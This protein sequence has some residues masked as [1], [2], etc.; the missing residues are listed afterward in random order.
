MLAFNTFL[1]W[2]GGQTKFACGPDSALQLPICKF[3]F[4]TWVLCSEFQ[5]SKARAGKR[6]ELPGSWKQAGRFIASE[7]SLVQF[8]AA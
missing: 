8:L 1:K 7:R 4:E 6:L 2:Q 5:P 3:C